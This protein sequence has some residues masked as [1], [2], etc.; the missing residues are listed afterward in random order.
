[1][2]GP[3]IDVLRHTRW[4][5][6]IAR[7]VRGDYG[8]LRGSQEEL[9]LEAEAHLVLVEYAARFDGSKVA[10]GSTADAL[11]EGWAAR[12]VRSRCRRLAVQLRNGGTFRTTSSKEAQAIRVARIPEGLEAGSGADAPDEDDTAAWL[13]AHGY[14]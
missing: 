5:R 7:G 11:F 4:A 10:P 2:P 9:E 8:Y 6:A 13:R 3:V 14:H 1:V 12:E